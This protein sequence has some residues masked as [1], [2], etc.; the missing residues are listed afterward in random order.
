MEVGENGICSCKKKRDDMRV[1]MKKI[2]TWFPEIEEEEKKTNSRSTE[3]RKKRTS[4]QNSHLASG[5]NT[6]IND[7]RK[8]IKSY[9]I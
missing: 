6:N 3:T 8:F 2:N 4:D 7:D 5:S 1:I 9:H